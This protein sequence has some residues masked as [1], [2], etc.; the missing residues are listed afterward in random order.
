[1]PVIVWS[2][3]ADL[4]NWAPGYDLSSG[5]YATFDHE[6]IPPPSSVG[7]DR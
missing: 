3:S 2:R 7:R 1:M 6:Q 4:P 5:E